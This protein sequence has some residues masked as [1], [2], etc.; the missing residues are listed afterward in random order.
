MTTA[1]A[2]FDDL[3][4]QPH[5]ARF[6][7][8]IINQDQPSH[9]Y[10]FLGPRGAGKLGAARRLAAALCCEQGG[11]GVCPSCVKALRDAHPDI[12]VV[13]PTGS[14]I[15]IEQ[16]RE[17][18]GSLSLRPFESRA[19]VFI[20]QDAE[21]FNAA[22]ANAFLKSLEEPPSFVY[23]ILLATSE[24]RLL[25]TLVSRCQPVRFNAVPVAEIEA[26]LLANC[27]ARPAEARAYALIVAGN[28]D[29][30][31]ELCRDEAMAQRRRHYIQIG[32]NLCKGAWEGG[33]A[34]MAAQITS[35]AEEKAQAAFESGPGPDIPDGFITAPKK[36]REEDA[37]RQG[38]QARRRELNFALDVMESWFRDLL[39]MGAGAG[40]AVLNKDYE[41]ELEDRALPSRLAGYRQ[42]L[43]AIAATRGK[44]GYNVDME[45]ALQAMF[46]KLQEVL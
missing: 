9:A 28:L 25:A 6:L 46:F 27:Q 24:D 18:N 7:A 34:A 31:V 26:H 20:F 13:S 22:S 41:L 36:R 21:S 8:A 4:G 17:V 30:A 15:Q 10:L 5:A 33:A 32:D 2:I 1:T 16:V 35:A 40:D 45:L 29:L 38:A 3:I 23:F 43:Q 39:V 12:Q 14:F 42:A 11:C 44:L 37:R 19:R